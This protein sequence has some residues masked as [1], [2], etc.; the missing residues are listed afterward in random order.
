ACEARAG[1]GS[2]LVDPPACLASEVT[3]ALVAA[4]I[5]VD[6]PPMVG[7]A[8]DVVELVELASPPLRDLVRHTLGASDNLYAECLRSALDTVSPRE[9]GVADGRITALLVD[10]GVPAEQ[11]R[12]V[13]GSGLS[14]YSLLSADALAR[15][16]TWVAVQPWGAELIEL[17]PVAGRDGTLATRLVGTPVDGRL[18]AK[19]GSMSGVRNLVGYVS[20]ADGEPLAFAVLFN[21]FVAPQAQ[22]IAVQDRVIL[23]I[24]ASDRR[25]RVPR[26]TVAALTAAGG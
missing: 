16:S 3:R 9:P 12:L 5:A 4:G 11:A 8:P 15:V 17:L 25:G 26:R 13:D 10:S 18:R 19:T 14:R 7:P 6:G 1:V 22:A 23:L 24:A 2:P 20:N 21:G